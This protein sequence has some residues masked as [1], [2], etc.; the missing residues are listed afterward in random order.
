MSADDGLSLS[1][2]RPD[3]VNRLD[4]VAEAISALDNLIASEESL[5]QALQRVANTAV[6]AIADVAAVSITVVHGGTGRTAAYTDETVLA[7]DAEQYAAGRGPCLEAAQTRRPVRVSLVTDDDRWPEFS[8][9]SRQ[10]GV[11]ATLSIPLVVAA[12]T[13]GGDDELIGSLNAYGHHTGAFDLVDEKLLCL[14]TDAASQAI[15]HARRWRRLEQTVLQLEQALVSR[16]DIDQAKGA[17]RAV[18][19][20]TAEQAFASL[21]ERSQRDNVKLRD[22][23]RQI[24]DRL[25][26]RPS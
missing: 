2:D 3:V 24:L 14:Y 8:S 25:S 12:A 26:Q 23:A 20:G 16:T 18:N 7:L 11:H 19:G 4:S 6:S 15:V 22:L 21:V 1:A 10:R 5:D 9:A 17:L 13:P